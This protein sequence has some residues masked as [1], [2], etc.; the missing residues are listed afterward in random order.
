MTFQFSKKSPQQVT[1][2]AQ[3]K[4]AAEEKVER[5]R[6]FQQAAELA[7]RR[8]ERIAAVQ[9]GRLSRQ[10]L[11]ES[12]RILLESFERKEE[13]EQRPGFFEKLASRVAGTGLGVLIG[14][15]ITATAAQ[16]N[17]CNGVTNPFLWRL[18]GV[19]GGLGAV[20]LAIA[21]A[22]WLFRQLF[23]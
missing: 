18:A 21:A 3:E 10:E 6:V 4:S 14:S 5:R 12:E 16:P 11:D 20:V 13:T 9:A 17:S 23:L 2:P 19:L 7:R 1:Q 8:R 15:I 22:V